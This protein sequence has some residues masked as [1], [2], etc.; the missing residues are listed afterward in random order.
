M[1]DFYIVTCQRAFVYTPCM[2]EKAPF[3]LEQTLCLCSYYDLVRP[4]ELIAINQY[5]FSLGQYVQREVDDPYV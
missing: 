4:Q 5:M 1:F 3:P 2:Y